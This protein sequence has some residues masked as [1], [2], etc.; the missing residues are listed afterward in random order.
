MFLR[1]SGIGRNPITQKRTQ[2]I[3]D[4]RLKKRRAVNL[5]EF[6]SLINELFPLEESMLNTNTLQNF[7][8]THIRPNYF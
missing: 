2:S 6:V 4:V 5:N 1:D 3:L 8:N 7:V